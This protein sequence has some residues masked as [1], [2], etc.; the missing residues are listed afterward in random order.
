MPKRL[1]ILLLSVLCASGVLAQGGKKSG[2]IKGKIVNSATKT[3]YNDVKVSI[4]ELGIFV[5]SEGQGE[6][7][8]TEV[9]FGT[10]S[11]VVGGGIAKKDTLTITVDKDIVDA[12]EIELAPNDKGDG[13]EASGIPT[14]TMEDNHSQ[15]DENSSSSSESSAGF[16]VA[17]SD[18]F[19]RI[20]GINFG[21]YRFRPRGYD[22]SDVQINGV[23]LTDQETGYSSIGQVGGLNDVLHDR[24]ITYGLRPSEFSFGTPK[25]TTQINATAA[26]QRKGSTV[27]YYNGNRTFRNRV[28]LTHNTGILKNGWAYS[29]SIS[30]RWAK[31]GY[32]E[33]TFYDGNSFYAAAS[34]MTK[35]G[36]FNLTAFGA[37][38]IRGKSAPVMDELYDLAGSKYYNPNWGYQDGKKRNAKVDEGFQPAIIANYTYRPNNKMRWNTALAYHFGKYK[39]SDIDFYNGYNPHPDYY[40]NLPSYFLQGTN[41]PFPAVAAAVRAQI[42]ANPDQLQ[43]NWDRLYN[44]N[45]TNVVS[46]KDANGIAGNTVTG[47]QSIYAI[48]NQVN[49]MKKIVLNSTFEN[50]IDGH[51]TIYGGLQVIR[52]QDEYYKQM[53]DLLGGDFYIN[54]NQFAVQTAVSNPNYNQNNLDLP[55]QTIKVGDKYGY[56]YKLTVLNTNAWGQATFSY[57][58]F[59]A[60]GALDLGMVSFNREGMVRNGLFPDN[61]FGKSVNQNFFLY[62][63]KG[64][65]TYNINLRN[66]VYLNLGYLTDAPRVDFTY[67]SDKSRDFTV[68]DPKAYTTKTMEMGYMFKF[69][70]LRGRVTLYATDV[71]DNTLI[72]RFF[73]D[74]GAFQTFVNYVMQGVDTRSIGTE[75]SAIYKLRNDLDVTAIAAVGQSFY[76]DRPLVTIYQD[77][78]PS[79]SAVGR[80]VYIKNYYLGVGPQSIYG[81]NFYYHPRGYWHAGLNFNYLDRNYLEV[82]PDRF[83][84][85]AVGLLEPGST[86]WDNILKQEMLPS[87]YTVDVS[88]GKSFDVSDWFKSL[89]HRTLLAVNVGVVNVLNNQN[90]ITTAYQQLR[91]DFANSNPQKFPSKY[92]YAF[93][94]NYYATVSLKF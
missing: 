12:G 31:E 36:Q 47:K 84:S 5:M 34:K 59:F 67:I 37:Q 50:A 33:G 41:T 78:D 28:M 43:I 3:P 62:K 23:P 65:V 57:N 89:K 13:G 44:S 4:P 82:N 53:A 54:M 81:L 77:N 22:N 87:S 46:V 91:Y 15:D 49:D 51:K 1:L 29:A 71:T 45:Y 30:R 20:A 79:K 10:H 55:N 72:K 11:V 26:D 93:G 21:T 74:D 18:P 56:H 25:G 14:I 92:S 76:T 63:A 19:L 70:K 38:T 66:S 6:F 90:I 60:F 64:G 68:T 58:R 48:G 16:Y 2:I 27:S 75:V 73:N 24:V 42:M 32:V 86:Q 7:S 83:T 40:K 61:S 94:I 9:P 17:N 88:G 52:Q 39:R 85:Q 80:Q 35:N 8:I 69:S